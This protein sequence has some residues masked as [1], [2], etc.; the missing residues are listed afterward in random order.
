MFIDTAHATPSKVLPMVL[1]GVVAFLAAAPTERVVRYATAPAPG[2]A[3]ALTVKG[4]PWPVPDAILRSG[5]LSFTGHS[6]VGTFVGTT[7]AVSGAIEGSP[8]VVGTR[9][10][11]EAPVASLS[12]SNDRRDRD[13]RATMEVDKYPTM[14][15]DLASVTLDSPG[16]PPDTV[17]T[18]LHGRLTIHGVTRDVTIPAALVVN[19]GAIDV[20]G[21]FPL[22]LVDYRIG[23]LTRFLG[24]LRMQR[25]IE[26]TFRLR[27][28]ATPDAMARARER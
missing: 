24:A 28:E 3:R 5:T 9:G 21:G 22:D 14:R 12:T 7:T 27:F 23:G 6:T 25:N 18:T 26:V 2:P 11:V 13:L 15:F 1:A 4:A 16:V 8:D 19:S 17:R 20:T 10:R